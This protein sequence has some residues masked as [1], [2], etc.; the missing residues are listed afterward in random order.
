MDARIK[1]GHDEVWPV[2]AP[3]LSSPTRHHDLSGF[4]DSQGVIE[5]NMSR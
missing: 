3:D 1:S 2:R 4:R 5:G